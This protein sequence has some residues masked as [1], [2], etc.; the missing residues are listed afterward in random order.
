[1][2]I[3]N[4]DW[5]EW[6]EPAIE[7]FME[8][9]VHFPGNDVL[10]NDTNISNI[11]FT[12]PMFSSSSVLFG[13]PNPGT[14][15]LEIIDFEQRFNPVYNNELTDGIQIDLYLG[16]WP[17][18]IEGHLGSNIVTSFEQPIA[19]NYLGQ[20]VWAS[21]VHIDNAYLYPLS[22]YRLEYT[23]IPNGSSDTITDWF[24]VPGDWFER[25]IYAITQ[26]DQY[27]V[28]NVIIR[29]V[30]PLKQ[31]YGVFYSTE[32]SY[33]TSSHTAT[34]EFVD[35]LDK[36]LLTDNR[37]DSQDPA[38]NVD[39]QEF[40]VELIELY[41]Q[42]D[43]ALEATDTVELPYSFYEDTQATTI[44]K[45]VEALGASLISAH[46]GVFHLFKLYW[47]DTGIT[48]TDGDVESYEFRQSSVATY[49]SVSV[50]AMIPSRVF[51]KELLSLENISV[52]W[53]NEFYFSTPRVFNVY[54]VVTSKEG[55]KYSDWWNADFNSIF[56]RLS[57]S[58]FFKTFTVYGST[59]ELTEQLSN[60]AFVGATPY[61]ISG[62]SYIPNTVYSEALASYLSEY[63]FQPYF[64][65][66][67]TIRGCYGI[68]VGAKIHITSELYGADADYIVVDLAYT[69]SGSVHTTLTM[70]RIS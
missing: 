17:L 8:A 57:N 18:D 59:I 55:N 31:R 43:N 36:L 64:T 19:V 25:H 58:Q 39:L 41:K 11:D 47:Y 56:W 66:K 5:D 6:S 49:D 26:D 21:V 69:Y 9:I 27:T 45:G 23:Y 65:I 44:N 54:A 1:M 4:I 48:L 61:E 68:W 38:I 14:G 37:V 3:P 30:L 40:I 12:V 13:P 70:Q 34:V 20:D 50:S 10:L 28:V 51:N 46:D 63:I 7:P 60:D 29:E 22:R 67:A 32:W 16:L 15:S 35:E 33:D 52:A 62:N 42:I 2:A 24:E 53:P